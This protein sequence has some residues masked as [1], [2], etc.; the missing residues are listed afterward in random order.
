[1]ENRIPILKIKNYLVV[2]I[3]IDMDDATVAS[4]QNDILRRVEE[5]NA[6]GVLIDISV[7]DMVDSYLGRMLGD[8][9]RMTNLMDA[10]VVLV[11]MQPAVAITLI[12]L[13]LRLEGIHTALNMEMGI[14][15]LEKIIPSGMGKSS[16]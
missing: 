6:S 8:T 16:L 3:Q 11:G 7:I 9:A 1:M 13:G 10:K 4:L 12:E 15:L 14:E 5:T 2:P